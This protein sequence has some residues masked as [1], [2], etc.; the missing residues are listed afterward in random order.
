MKGNTPLTW[1]KC[2]VKSH[3]V[4]G[5]SSNIT[6]QEMKWKAV[7]WGPQAVRNTFLPT[8]FHLTRSLTVA[9]KIVANFLLKIV[10]FIYSIPWQDTLL[11][12]ILHLELL[13][14]SLFYRFLFPTSKCH[15]SEKCG[16]E[17]CSLS[18]PDVY[19]LPTATVAQ[20]WPL[21]L[22]CSLEISTRTV[23][24]VL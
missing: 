18:L 16:P 21:S 7:R 13:L 1:R 12:F 8:P 2:A 3:W 23:T 15:G 5:N 10:S 9:L 17:P 19:S 6:G 4:T 14:H 24:G 20:S 22:H 11:I